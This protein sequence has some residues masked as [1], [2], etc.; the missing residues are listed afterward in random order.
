MRYNTVPDIT[1]KD[2]NGNSFPIKDIR[3][4]REF[5]TALQIDLKK[6]DFLDEIVSRKENYGDGQEDLTFTVVDHNIVKIVEAG[7]DLSK[8]KKINLPIVEEGF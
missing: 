3:P 7:W 1:F 6:G 8:L 2:I 5:E 4:I